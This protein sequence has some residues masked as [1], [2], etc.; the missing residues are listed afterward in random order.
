MNIDHLEDICGPQF[1]NATKTLSHLLQ[2]LYAAKY[3][4]KFRINRL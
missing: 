3:I 4:T 1:L 2:C